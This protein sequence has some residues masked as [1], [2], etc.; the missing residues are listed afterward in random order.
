MVY[1]LL[2][3]MGL[4]AAALDGWGQGAVNVSGYVYDGAGNGLELVVIQ[5]RGTA[6]GAVSD[7]KGYYSLRVAG[8]DSVVILYSCLGYNRAER[9]LVRPGADSRVNVRMSALSIS[10]GE[11]SVTAARRQVSSMEYMDASKVRTI[12]DPGGGGIESLV[13]TYAGVSSSNEL[14]SQ[15]S[16]RGGS[17]DENIVYVNGLEVFRPLLIRS[18]QQEGLSFV[19]PDLTGAVAFAAGGFEARYG[20]KMSSVLDITYKKPEAFEGSV[21]AGLLGGSAYVGGAHKGLTHVTGV[22]FKTSKSLLG[23][24]DTDAEYDPVFV[25]L[26]TFITLGLRNGWEV[27]FLGNIAS[28]TFDFAPRSRSTSFG[29]DKRV[30]G[31]NVAFTGAEKDRF[32]TLFGAL[33][34]KKKVSEGLEAGLQFSVFNNNEE[35]GYDISGA[36]FIAENEDPAASNPLEVGLYHEHARNSLHALVA[37][38]GHYGIYKTGGNSLLWGATVQAERVAGK[39]NEW[40][41]RD[42][43]GYSLPHRKDGVY[44]L[45]NLYSSDNIEGVRLSAYLQDIFK[46]RSPAGLFTLIG[47]VR[48]SYWTYNNEFILSP[49]VSAAFAP[50][51]NNNITLRAATGLYYQPPFYKELRKVVEDGDG[52][53]VVELNSHLLSQR[54]F[55]IIA[56]GD[57]AFKADGRNFKITAEAYFKYLDR[58][59]PY[60]VDNVKIRYYGENCARGYMAGVDLKLFG[61]FVP[62][63]DSW[64]SVSLMKGEQVINSTVTAPLPNDPGYSLSLFFQDYFPRFKR[65]SL[66]L[67]GILS[68][69]LPVTAPGKGYESG[70]YETSPYRRVDMGMSYLV[71]GA[72]DAF[73]ERGFLRGIRNIRLSLDVFNLFDIN[74]VSSYMWISDVYARQFAVPNYLTGRRLNV[75]VSVDF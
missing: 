19:N 44:T 56:G 10:L 27:D 47:G 52:N 38:A 39:I 74:N 31:F 20:D 15:Y 8:G 34:V 42:S 62:G 60:T 3:F 61:E 33:T 9:I 59:N 69:R 45:S 70:Y 72:G 16:V 25:D 51:I 12:A 46:F 11:V 40:E 48:G 30:V 53:S 50:N 71:G 36:Y 35:E 4:L 13:V 67:R 6:V 29:T 28:N 22:R 18:G 57:Y 58:L 5:V 17:Y 49:R 2:V 24:L 26:Q 1:R 68:G 64:L 7:A 32:N 75:R 37:N 21:S 41:R 55:H 73:M 23:T 65:V 66:N 14:S 43:A 63:I 54:S